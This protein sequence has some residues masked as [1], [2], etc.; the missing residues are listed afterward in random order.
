MNKLAMDHIDVG[1]G[2]MCDERGQIELAQLPASSESMNERGTHKSTHQI[3]EM[4]NFA[5][6]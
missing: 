5:G 6:N 3:R 2:V 4:T 1:V